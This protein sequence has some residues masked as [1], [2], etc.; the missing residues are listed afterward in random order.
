M[1]SEKKSTNGGQNVQVRSIDEVKVKVWKHTTLT[2]EELERIINDS[3]FCH[4]MRYLID[5]EVERRME[6]Y[7]QECHQVQ[8]HIREND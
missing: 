2:T 7:V 8:E 5:K 1:N 6:K 3:E 4:L